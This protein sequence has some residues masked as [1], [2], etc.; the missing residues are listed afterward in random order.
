MALS[1]QMSMIRFKRGWLLAND[2]RSFVV[3]LMA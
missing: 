1:S 2:Q 3:G